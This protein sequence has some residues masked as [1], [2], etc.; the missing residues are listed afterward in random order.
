VSVNPRSITEAERPWLEQWHRLEV[1]GALIEAVRERHGNQQALGI[2]GYIG[3]KANGLVDKTDSKTRARYRKVLDELQAKGITP[4]PARGRSRRWSEVG[5]ADLATVA[6]V[7]GGSAAAVAHSP[8][9]AA[10]A[11]LFYITYN[12]ADPDSPAPVGAGEGTIVRIESASRRP[13][14]APAARLAA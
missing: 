13:Q 2:A 10:V 9:G 1:Q 6:A 4:P 5:A 12:G 7:A 11:G 14:R 3:A 8:V